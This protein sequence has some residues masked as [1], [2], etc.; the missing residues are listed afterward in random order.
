M[1]GSAMKTAEGSAGQWRGRTWA[2]VVTGLF[3]L[4]L[5]GLWRFGSVPW[6]ATRQPEAVPQWRWSEVPQEDWLALFDPT[7]FVHGHWQSFSGPGWMHPPPVAY[8]AP[9][10]LEPPRF[11]EPAELQWIETLQILDSASTWS[12]SPLALR[13][14]TEMWTGDLA[15]RLR[16]TEGTSRLRLASEI[17]PRTLRQDPPPLPGWPHGDLLTNSVVRLLVDP[18]GRVLTA[19]LLVSS[20]LS[21][22]DQ[23]ALEVA[24][25]LEF[26]A[27]APQAGAEKARG[28]LTPVLAVFEWQT[29][30][31]G[32]TVSAPAPG[33][34]N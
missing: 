23:K 13:V 12:P 22:A 24:R 25:Q 3:V 5:A 8:S 26:E 16:W 33:S 11:L 15:P 20:G 29:L 9:I 31:P 1:M 4:H 18:F 10:T 6:P 30:A 32:T 14:G 21:Q 28:D 19:T 2:M 34:S 27:L 7:F 17:Q